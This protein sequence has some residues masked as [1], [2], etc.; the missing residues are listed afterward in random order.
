MSVWDIV[1]VSRIG[2]TVLFGIAPVIL[3]GVSLLKPRGLYY[4]S[5][6]TGVYFFMC[7]CTMEYKLMFVYLGAYVAFTVFWVVK[8]GM[9]YQKEGY[10]FDLYRELFESYYADDLNDDGINDA[11]DNWKI[12][13]DPRFSWIFASRKVKR[14]RRL[15]QEYGKFGN[16]MGYNPYF[17]D[18]IRKMAR[19]GAQSYFNSS[20]RNADTAREEA[21]REEAAREEA[22]RRRRQQEEE[23]RARGN[24][25]RSAQKQD[26]MDEAQRR[27]AAQHEFARRF[28]LRYFA[29]CTSKEEGKKLY[30]KYAAK[31]HPDNSVTG[32][33]D[34]FIKI[35]EEYNRFSQIDD[36]DFVA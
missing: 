10:S 27:V 16:Y 35:D 6:G 29:M 15:R 31:Y 32:D 17:G 4:M 1:D 20:D 9:Q 19:E 18:S 12:A 8:G 30:H 33:K 24:A 25:S 11:F 5:V 14:E 3:L 36:W 13:H 28:N 2:F 22:I 34:K 7:L 21:A 23:Y 26:Q